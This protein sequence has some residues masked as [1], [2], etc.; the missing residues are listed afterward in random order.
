MEGSDASS[1]LSDASGDEFNTSG[2]KSKT[3]SRKKTQSGKKSNQ[4]LRLDPGSSQVKLSREQRDW[5]TT[6]WNT[7]FE[8]TQPSIIAQH[9]PRVLGK[10]QVRR[11]ADMIEKSGKKI[12][13]NVSAYKF[14]EWNPE[15]SQMSRSTMDI[16]AKVSGGATFDYT[17]KINNFLSVMQVAEE[18]NLDAKYAR[19]GFWNDPDMMVVG[20]Q[21][22]SIE[23]QKSHFSLWCIMSS[24]LFLGNDPRFMTKDEKLLITNR[25]AIKVNQDSTEQGVR[26]KQS[27][28]TEV[29]AKK[30]RDG[31]VAVLLLN[32]SS[33]N[34]SDITVTL[35]DLGIDSEMKVEDIYENKN[36]G[37]IE[38]Q[39]TTKLNPQTSHF[40]LLSKK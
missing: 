23:E 34:A 7:M 16:A 36:L 27:G 39:F 20:S 26:I 40:I 15:V 8:G 29:W 24:P 25:E 3:Q 9:G 19:P 2:S 10:E 5:I 4:D 28:D 33:Y 21:G 14:R 18:N 13:L 37:K 30:M 6:M 1:P 32:R 11:W 38:S 17:K 22:L 31:K 35:K 12:I